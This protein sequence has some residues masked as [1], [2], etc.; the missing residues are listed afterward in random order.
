MTG[1]EFDFVVPNSLE[2]LGLYERIFDVERLEVTAYEAGRNEAVFTMYGTRFHLLDENPD[3]FLIAPRPGDPIPLWLN[4]LVPDTQA[5]F[6]KAVQA[7][8][9]VAQP[10]TDMA[11]MG[12]KT[13]MFKDPYG[14]IWM[15]TEIIKEVSFEERLQILEEQINQESDNG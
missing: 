1:V 4:I 5:A 14:Y 13:A 9:I 12:V 15:L 8:C 11:A 7:G 3:Y 6:D 10:V 2:A